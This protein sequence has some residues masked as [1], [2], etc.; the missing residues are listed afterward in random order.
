MDRIALSG[1]QV[2][3][4]HGVL[5]AERELGQRF[6]IDVLLDGDFSAAAVSDDLTQALD[7]T[8]VHRLVADT[9]ARETFQLIEALA[10][11][12]CRVLLQNLVVEA[13]T[14]TVHKPNPPIPHFQ[15]SAAVTMK[16]TRAWLDSTVEEA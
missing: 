1:I 9:A 5:E 13:V 16:R 12:L 8:V 4:Y 7:Y 6:T 10:G 11:R 14:V 15:G 2:Y 3:G